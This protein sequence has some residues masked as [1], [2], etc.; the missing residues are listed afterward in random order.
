MR[1]DAVGKPGKPSHNGAVLGV[2]GIDGPWPS[3]KVA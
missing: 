3:E 1:A 2:L